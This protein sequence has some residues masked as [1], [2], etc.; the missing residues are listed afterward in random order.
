MATRHFLLLIGFSALAALTGCQSAQTSMVDSLPQPTF[1]GPTFDETPVT[2]TPPVRP[3]NPYGR[4]Q[5]QVRPE[6][7]IPASWIPI[8]KP[9]H[10]KWIVIHHSA[11][12]TGGAA[13]FDKMHRAKGWDELGYHFVIGNGTDT[14]DG[15]VEV[16]SRWPK[17]KWGAH[18]KTPDNRYNEYGIGICLVGNFDITH[19]TPAQMRSLDKL[20]AYLMHT[21][22]ISPED[23]IGHRDTKKT[24][25]P[26]HNMDVQLVRN[27]AERLLAE[28]GYPIPRDPTRTANADT[29]L[30]TDIKA[31]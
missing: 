31:R 18:A 3:V 13:A 22:N 29:E 16:G 8:A 23:V 20:V 27:G 11:T 2:P 1:S 26:G 10:W 21:Y 5:L 17:Q 19:P 12:A 15:L 30:L 9:N 24:D 7:G 6:P 25:C 4:Q 14:A 28:E